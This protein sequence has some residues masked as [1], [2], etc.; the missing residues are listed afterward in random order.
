M[1]F[2]INCAILI[3]LLR[4]TRKKA[5]VVK[6]TKAFRFQAMASRLVFMQPRVQTDQQRARRRTHRADLISWRHATLTSEAAARF[7][8]GLGPVA[9]GGM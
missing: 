5:L 4:E 8:P 1:A 6:S 2:M 7:A 3:A 9:R